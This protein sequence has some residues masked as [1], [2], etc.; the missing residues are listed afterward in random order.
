MLPC[1]V[2]IEMM[3]D[4]PIFQQNQ[5]AVRWK[6]SWIGKFTFAMNLLHNQQYQLVYEDHF[7]AIK[8]AQQ[9]LPMH[10]MLSAWW[11][12]GLNIKVIEEHVRKL[13]TKGILGKVKEMLCNYEYRNTNY[14]NINENMFAQFREIWLYGKTM[15]NQIIQIYF[16]FFF[17]L[18]LIPW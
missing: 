6:W 11:T 4:R 9:G 18:A 2:A 13:W 15:V 3:T 12:V 14:D 17:Q 10:T 5:P 1:S 7:F 8:Q 16:I